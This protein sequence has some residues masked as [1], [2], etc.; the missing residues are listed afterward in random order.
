MWKALELPNMSKKLSLK[1]S[2]ASWNQKKNSRDNNSQN[3]WD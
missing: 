3:I 1:E 2:G